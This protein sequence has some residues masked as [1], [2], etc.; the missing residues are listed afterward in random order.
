MREAAVVRAEPG[1]RVRY[2]D[3][4][5]PSRE[6]A[7]E[8]RDVADE[9]LPRGRMRDHVD[10]LGKIDEHRALTPPQD[11]VCGEVAVHAF[12]REHARDLR[13]E[14]VPDAL[15]GRAVQV[16]GLEPWRCDEAV[17]DERHAVAVL[18]P[19]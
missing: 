4:N 11:V 3:S 7:R 16:D 14:L 15:R 10:S 9:Q 13:D 12:G 2:V 8:R 19:L 17:L 18:W 6:I 5:A 1:E